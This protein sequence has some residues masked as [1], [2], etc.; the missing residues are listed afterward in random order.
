M[1]LR[2][3][4]TQ[5]RIGSRAQRLKVRGGRCLCGRGAHLT[6]DGIE[7]VELRL[8]LRLLALGRHLRLHT[9]HLFVLGARDFDAVHVEVGPRDLALPLV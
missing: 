2:P 3:C 7:L 6:L 8:Q 5:P 1:E 4:T 9:L